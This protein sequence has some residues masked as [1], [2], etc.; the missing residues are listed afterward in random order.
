MLIAPSA[1][2]GRLRERVSHKVLLA[3]G[4]EGGTVPTSV[5]SDLLLKLLNSPPQKIKFLK[6]GFPL[7][8]GCHAAPCVALPLIN[9]QSRHKGDALKE[10][11]GDH[12]RSFPS[13]FNAERHTQGFCQDP[14]LRLL[15]PWTPSISVTM[16][17]VRMKPAA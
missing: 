11:S 15:C 9:L 14:A 12:V 8:D 2:P 17:G 6:D 5:R 16:Q 3:S 4:I 10:C 13:F 7:S 1:P